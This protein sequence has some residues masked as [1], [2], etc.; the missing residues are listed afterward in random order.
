MKIKM[1]ERVLYR[2]DE[3]RIEINPTY[4]D[5]HSLYLFKKNKND[6]GYVFPRGI[7]EELA[8]S[9]WGGIERKIHACNELILYKLRQEEI[10]ID[11][12]HVAVCQAYMEEQRRYQEYFL[13]EK[14]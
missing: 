11:H 6:G 14:K 4:P 7:L 2:D 1:E 5:E 3:I 13:E 10:S 8:K 9:N 12:L